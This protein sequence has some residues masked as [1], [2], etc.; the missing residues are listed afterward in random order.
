L[1]Y[2]N[3]YNSTGINEIIDEAGIAK[4]TLY[5]HFS[6]KEQICIA[7]LEHMQAVFM[8]NIEAFVGT[9]PVGRKRLL[10]IFD[11]LKQF[12][13]GEEF[14][15]C[16]C[17]NTISEVAGDQE[18]IRT[19]IRTQKDGFLYFIQEQVNE[20]YPDKDKRNRTAIAKQIYLLYEGAVSESYLLQDQWPIATAKATCDKLLE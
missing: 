8:L 19:T 15:G 3:G 18:Q 16:W 13:C 11:F 9:K 6:S 5:N 17:V 4:A 12:Y 7:Y 14:N 2:N 1:F 10:A 20:V